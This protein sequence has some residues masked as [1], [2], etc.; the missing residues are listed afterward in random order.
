MSVSVLRF[1]PFSIV[2]SS[3]SVQ[4]YSTVRTAHLFVRRL[5][6]G[7]VEA[8]HQLL[9]QIAKKTIAAV[10]CLPHTGLEPRS[11][12]TVCCFAFSGI[13]SCFFQYYS[14]GDF[15]PSTCPRHSS[16]ERGRWNM[17]LPTY[18]ARLVQTRDELCP[19][20][21]TASYCRLSKLS[22]LS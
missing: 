9:F 12:T 18:N 2:G 17:D 14:T 20:G 11:K 7:W 6:Q 21:C 8:K 10:V 19:P 3:D 16:R 5:E 1:L 4:Q 13:L 22:F 15:V